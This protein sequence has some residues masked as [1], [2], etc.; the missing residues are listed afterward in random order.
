MGFSLMDIRCDP[1]TRMLPSPLETMPVTT[2]SPSSS[3]STVTP[4]VAGRTN[5]SEW[6]KKTKT[7]V[8]QVDQETESETLVSTQALGLD[9]KYA[10]SQAEAEDRQKLKNVT[11]VKE[12]LEKYKKRET[13]SVQEFTALLGPV[14]VDH[15]TI[16]AE[17]KQTE[18][19]VVRIT[20]NQLQAGKRV[21][22]ITDTSGSS[23]KD[24]IVLT[25]D[26]SG[27]ESKMMVNAQAKSFPGSDAENA[28]PEPAQRERRIYGIIKCF[29]SNVH[30]CTIIVKCKVISGTLELHNC[31]KVHVQIESEAT[32]ATMQVDLSHDLTIDFRD[33]PSGKH[34]GTPGQAKLVSKTIC[35]SVLLV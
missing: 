18:P 2:E 23:S 4:G 26:L 33:A 34:G 15:A 25:Q 20:R 35:A 11:K 7:L 14:L 5:Y 29:I 22:S 1:L 13:E 8:D 31:S 27:L 21:I 28:V 32:V 9:G 17:E 24:T 30:N 19:T 6:D 3:A 12:T 10:R 16:Q